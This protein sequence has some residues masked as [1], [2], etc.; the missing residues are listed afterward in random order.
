VDINELALAQAREKYSDRGWIY[1][2][3]RGED[4]P[5]P[6]S[7]VEY[8]LSSVALPYMHIPQAL[9]EVHRVLTSG[10]MFRATLH[11]PRFTCSEFR[12]AFPSPKATLFRLFVLVNGLAFHFSG[13]VLTVGGKSECC[14]TKRGMTKALKRAG[15]FEVRFWREGVK[16]FVEAKKL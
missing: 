10:G 1:L 13:K 9:S 8:V 15:F 7:S 3:G 2:H 4:L 11:S 12:K 5:L 14:Q 16:F 6:D